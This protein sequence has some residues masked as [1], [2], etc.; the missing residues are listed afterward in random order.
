MVQ[1]TWRQR[2]AAIRRSAVAEGFDVAR[3]VK[4]AT[5]GDPHG[6]HVGVSF[7]AFVPAH[8]AEGRIED[9]T[10]PL[11]RGSWVRPT[12]LCEAHTVARRK[13][14]SDMVA[15]DGDVDA[16]T[17]V[18][19]AAF[20]HSHV[21]MGN[22]RRYAWPLDASSRLVDLAVA[23]LATLGTGMIMPIEGT[24]A[25]MGTVQMCRAAPEPDCHDDESL[26]RS[27]GRHLALSFR[28]TVLLSIRIEHGG[29]AEMARQPA[30]TRALLALDR[31]ELA[32]LIDQH[33]V[34]GV[35]RTYGMKTRD[36]NMACRRRGI[37]LARLAA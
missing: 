20:V 22:R 36:V 9:V 30:D 8:K 19:V 26:D 13:V 11:S 35:C 14:L 33:G 1:E 7:N 28:D 5:I 24:Y 37:D 21:T 17:A 23:E 6:R 31:D 25:L 2:S 32:R 3:L 15:H 12:E 27:I 4:I 16:Q 18:L 29:T 10:L 34:D